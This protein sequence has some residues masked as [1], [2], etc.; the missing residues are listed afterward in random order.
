MGIG[1][2][3]ADAVIGS[4]V[5]F[6][7]LEP[8]QDSPRSLFL[9]SCCV[10]LLATDNPNVPQLPLPVLGVFKTRVCKTPST[11]KVKVIIAVIEHPQCNGWLSHRTRPLS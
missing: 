2:D 8:W 4:S 11:D 5:L 3:A 7:L 10:V 1:D 6:N 9:V